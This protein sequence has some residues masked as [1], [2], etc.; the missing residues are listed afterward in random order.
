MPP[1]LAEL[2]R[3]VR[4]TVPPDADAL[5]PYET[6]PRGRTGRAAFAAA[7][8][9]LGELRAALRWAYDHRVP[10]V[11]RG[12]GHTAAAVP[13]AS[14]TQGVLDLTGLN[15]APTVDP[16]AGTITAGAGV[17]LSA[18]DAALEP[19]GLTLPFG[20]P[21]DRTV[22]GLIGDGASGRRVVPG[23]GL[24]S[25]L[26]G[27]AAVL[28][29]AGATPL[30]LTDRPATGGDPS[31]FFVGAQGSLGIVTAARFTAVPR[32]LATAGAV[33]TFPDEPA[34]LAL[35]DALH[36]SA[37][38]V[39]TGFELA[40]TGLAGTDRPSA[41]IRLADVWGELPVP[42]G[43]LLTTLVTAHAGAADI[44]WLGDGDP[45]PPWPA[46]DQVTAALSRTGTVVE[47]DVTVPRE[48]V[49]RL[50]A[51]ARALAASVQP[52]ARVSDLGDAL[53]GR[54]RLYVTWPSGRPEP[55][56]EGLTSLVTRLHDV[57]V[58]AHQ[59]TVAAVSGAGSGNR[60]FH[61]RVLPP[62]A[63][64][65]A[66]RVKDAFDPRGLLGAPRFGPLRLAVRRSR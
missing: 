64:R 59:G 43:T 22:G 9:G 47:L 17:A 52:G 45:E 13:D 34:A 48:R 32:P 58:Y 18:L 5:A 8:D 51:D 37:P 44:A 36:R 35:F 42:V 62:A 6:G 15:D 21:G 14:G 65:A 25:S 49:T 38:H 28:A 63:G 12:A 41:L 66:G 7:P 56:P 30:P 4:R 26:L 27:V 3:Q 39:L 54:W 24:R 19:C 1:D 53:D 2:A 31:L 46:P 33:L 40:S 16:A 29:D 57:V 61:Q 60:G 20:A 10:L 55:S 11:P 50:R 23:G